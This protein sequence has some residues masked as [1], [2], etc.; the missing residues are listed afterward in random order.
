MRHPFYLSLL[1]VLAACAAPA[2]PTPD[3]PPV[4]WSDEFDGSGPPD[5]TKWNYDL[6][7]HGWG[8]NELQHY[9][10]RARNVRRENGYLVIE[11]HREPY[12]DNAYTSARLVTRDRATW[13]RGRLEVRAQLPS[14]RGTWPAIWMLGENI[15]KV[16]W[17][18]C[19]EIDI[20]E[21][22][23]YNP[24]SVFATVHTTAFNHVQGT[25]VGSATTRP[26]LESAFHVYA[27]DWRA[28]SLYFSI[29]D[30]VYFTFGKTANATNAE[31]PFDTPHYLL[32]NL[33]VGG[34][35]GGR[36]GVDTTIWPQRLLVDWVRVYE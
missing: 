15:G 35:W 3:A 36:E 20:M 12:A 11:A 4:V 24:D 28:D 19:G 2:T 29:D 5:S 27:L 9:T 17:P 32:L 16:G 26:D 8:N 25:Q 10:D 6:G 21:H 22:V 33:A 13:N 34:N 30:E 31:W 14:G 23:G 18:H 1:A 7:G